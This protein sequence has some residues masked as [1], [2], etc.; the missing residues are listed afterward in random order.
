MD[1]AK[2][3]VSKRFDLR[4]AKALEAK[5]PLATPE[6]TDSNAP[7]AP[8]ALPVPEPPQ[9]G[10]GQTFIEQGAE[11]DGTL[12]LRDSFRIDSEFRGEIVSE[13][14]VVIAESAGIEADVR[15]REV[16]IAGAMV[17]DVKAGRQVIIRA[18]GR[19]HGDVETPCLEVEKGAFFNGRTSMARPE[20]ALRPAADASAQPESGSDASASAPNAASA[21]NASSSLHS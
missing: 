6:T 20:S 13:G 3:W 5:P 16:E 15:A 9:P 14:R 21:G 4:S 2:N 11:F 7:G 1:D 19:L 12:R 18:G 8:A 17:G 10:T